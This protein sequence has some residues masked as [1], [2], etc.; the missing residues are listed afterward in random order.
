[1]GKLWNHWYQIFI[2]LMLHIWLIPLYVIWALYRW[3]WNPD[4]PPFWGVRCVQLGRVLWYLL[5]IGVIISIIA[6]TLSGGA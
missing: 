3:G 2:V 6:Y 5:G 1:M 4:T